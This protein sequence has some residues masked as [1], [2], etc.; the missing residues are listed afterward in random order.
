MDSLKNILVPS[1]Y[2]SCFCLV[3]S[4]YLFWLASYSFT[5]EFLIA[6]LI[7]FLSLLYSSGFIALLLNYPYLT[8]CS[9]LLSIIFVILIAIASNFQQSNG[10]QDSY[11]LCLGIM[12]LIFGI[13]LPSSCVPLLFF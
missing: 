10:S 11:F 4:L 5:H 8:T 2:L 7:I 13:L 1:C 12:P 9:L 6:S 3:V